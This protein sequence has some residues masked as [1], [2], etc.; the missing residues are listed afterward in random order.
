[1]DM[2]LNGRLRLHNWTRGCVAGGE[3]GSIPYSLILFCGVQAVVALGNGPVL[4]F[5]H[6]APRSTRLGGSL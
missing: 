1:M 3:C 5:D 4:E 2:S 6:L